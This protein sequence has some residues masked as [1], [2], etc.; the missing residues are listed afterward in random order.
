MM[1]H[2]LGL[3]TFNFAIQNEVNLM[4][5]SVEILDA[6]ISGDSIEELLLQLDKIAAN[7]NCDQILEEIKTSI[8]KLDPEYIRGK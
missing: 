5:Y 3:H 6:R 8:Q 2:D 4:K 7:S 1:S